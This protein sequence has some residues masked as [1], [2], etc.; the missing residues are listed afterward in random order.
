MNTLHKICFRWGV[1][2]FALGALLAT[3]VAYL[4]FPETKSLWEF[5]SF[6]GNLAR[7]DRETG[8][9]Q[10]LTG[11][12]WRTVEEIYS[13]TRVSHPV[14]RPGRAETAE[15]LAKRLVEGLK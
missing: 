10:L 3:G 1:I 12:G 2:G 5:K 7:F 4:V 6:G 11:N 9:T 14:N 8:R 15:E 13:G